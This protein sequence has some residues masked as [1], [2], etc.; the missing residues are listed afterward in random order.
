[1]KCKIPKKPEFACR[2]LKRFSQRIGDFSTYT[3]STT[4][5][6]TG[7][8]TLRKRIFVCIDDL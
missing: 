3:Y 2:I 1:M 7:V 8:G 4:R 6:Q 5:E